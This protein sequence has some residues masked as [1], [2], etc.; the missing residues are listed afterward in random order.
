VSVDNYRWL[1]FFFVFSLYY[2]RRDLLLVC[3]RRAQLP[4]SQHVNIVNLFVFSASLVNP[5]GV[6][7]IV[8]F[9]FLMFFPNPSPGLLQLH[10]PTSHHIIVIATPCKLQVV[11]ENK[12][13]LSHVHIFR[14][15]GL[16]TVPNFFFPQYAVQFL[17]KF[18]FIEPMKK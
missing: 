5:S 16:L 11:K 3:P 18:V 10:F 13:N 9:E 17:G 1:H 2:V 15:L 12:K 8:D 6:V 14:L 4:T 7:S